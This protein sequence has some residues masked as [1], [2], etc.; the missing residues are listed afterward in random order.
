MCNYIVERAEA[1][2]DLQRQIK[3][4]IS[5]RSV[6]VSKALAGQNEEIDFLKAE[7][8]STKVRLHD[9]L[10][11]SQAEKD[12]L[13]RH[14]DAS[15]AELLQQVEELRR[16]CVR[17]DET[18]MQSSAADNSSSPHI[19]TGSDSHSVEVAGNKH[20]P[21]VE[22]VSHAVDSSASLWQKLELLRKLVEAEKE[23][24][25][26]QQTDVSGQQS[27]ADTLD[28]SVSET[29][30]CSHKIRSSWV[31]LEEQV[32]PL[33]QI[34]CT[35]ADQ[36]N[37]PSN[38]EAEIN[39]G[40][41][42]DSQENRDG[43]RDAT[44]REK[45]LKSVREQ[46]DE[47]KQEVLRLNE[48]VSKMHLKDEAVHEMELK[49]GALQAELESA[50][51]Q[52]RNQEELAKNLS[53]DIESANEQLK[54][55]RAELSD[56][57]VVIQKLNGEMAELMEQTRQQ[58]LVLQTDCDEKLNTERKTWQ[59]QIDAITDELS[60]KCTVLEQHKLM[61][62]ELSDR[63]SVLT[64]ERD[65]KT[66]EIENGKTQIESLSREIN[67]VKEQLNSKTAELHEAQTCIEHERKVHKD[68]TE[69]EMQIMKSMVTA[70]EDEIST[71]RQQLESKTVE[72]VN[73]EEALTALDHRTVSEREELQA[74]I[75]GLEEELHNSQKSSAEKLD[76]L[77]KE[78]AM[79]ES[80][81]RELEETHAAYCSERESGVQIT[82]SKIT[83]L[84]DEISTLRQQLESKTVESVDKEE[85][86]TALDHRTVSEREELQ[87]KI[88]GL[89]DQLNRDQK[90]SVEKLDTLT[91][92]VAMKESAMRELEE[93]HAAYCKLTDAKLAE[94]SAAVSM[95]EDD[96]KS[97]LEQHKIELT[98]KCETFDER[99]AKLTGDHEEQL[100][101]L[102]SQISDLTTNKH[103]LESEVKML[104]DKLASESEN[105]GQLE[106]NIAELSLV[107]EE[108]ERQ[109][110]DLRSTLTADTEQMIKLHDEGIAAMKSALSDRNH[111]LSLL[112]AAL[113]QT[114]RE[115]VLSVDSSSHTVVTDGNDSSR[116]AEVLDAVSGDAGCDASAPSL[117][118]QDYDVPTMVRQISS[119]SAANRLLHDKIGG[120]EADLLQIRQTGVIPVDESHQHELASV[121]QPQSAL[122]S[123]G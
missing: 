111:S 10:S 102:N 73:K 59:S 76:I 24:W 31:V 4:L 57:D 75:A 34:L 120:L 64:L 5:N 82:N 66:A 117:C 122:C 2:T 25:K 85:A 107:K 8:T 35:A 30:G 32:L 21:D 116:E 3:E 88:A 90:S 70:V 26:L 58:L 79:K 29:A 71:L 121:S 74:K 61:L 101:H 95:K 86:L 43:D 80:A 19:T 12:A 115:D 39:S 48:V 44:E 51:E 104:K 105:I 109:L 112:N 89:E 15:R 83:A 96:T 87:A 37:V 123:S 81:I 110:E 69:S 28:G 65:A 63:C 46:L 36:D 84:E 40:H 56:K 118:A 68:E 97:L 14:A 11:Q 98:E 99:M 47:E 13:I 62:Q 42:L 103:S 93:S 92:E 50:C 1:V 41:M 6:E 94:L 45:T 7:L 77:K 113:S 119:L 114:C 53:A 54:Q 33:I 38:R 106:K 9:A 23:K 67:V 55:Q 27:A 18:E 91:K 60:A 72:L 22:T 20:V 16:A 78:V 52:L 49:C 108:C 100:A 17:V